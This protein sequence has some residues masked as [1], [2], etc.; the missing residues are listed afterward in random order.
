MKKK[1]ILCLIL[2]NLLAINV[3][4]SF[5]QEKTNGKDDTVEINEKTGFP[6]IEKVPFVVWQEGLTGCLGTRIIKKSD[7]S[8]FVWQEYMA[9]AFFGFKTRNME[10]INKIGRASCRERV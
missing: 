8:N 1:I 4:S 6:E 9:G 7:R 10:P 2:T 3:L 5:A